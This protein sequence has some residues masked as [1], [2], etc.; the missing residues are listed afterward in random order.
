MKLLLL[1]TWHNALQ[2][3]SLDMRKLKL[4]SY[5]FGSPTPEVGKPGAQELEKKRTL[6]ELIAV[7]AAALLAS[8]E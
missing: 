4:T 8:H 1:I 3:T 7:F 5:A 6:V 2:A